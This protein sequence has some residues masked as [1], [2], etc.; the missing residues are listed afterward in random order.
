MG[1]GSGYRTYVPVKEAGKMDEWTG[2]CKGKEADDERT[3]RRPDVVVVPT[4]PS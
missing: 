4:S 1:R 2:R 3:R